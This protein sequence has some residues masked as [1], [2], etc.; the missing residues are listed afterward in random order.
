MLN[1]NRHVRGWPGGVAV[2]FAHSA[3]AT[4]GSGVQIPGSDL[5]IAHQAIL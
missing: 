2:K 5:H 4:W 3:L 1:K